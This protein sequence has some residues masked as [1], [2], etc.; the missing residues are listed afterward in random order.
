MLINKIGT[1]K[2]RRYAKFKMSDQ[3][4]EVELQMQQ[5]IKAYRSDLNDDFGAVEKLQRVTR[6]VEL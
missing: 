4:E 5:V 1:T 2:P 3:R 6:L